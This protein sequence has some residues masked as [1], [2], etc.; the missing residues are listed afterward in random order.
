MDFEWPI[1]HGFHE[2]PIWTGR[3]FTI[4]G[5]KVSV[6]K[7]T[8]D[9]SGWNDSLTVFHETEASHGNHYID[10]ASRR[11]ALSQLKNV[12]DKEGSVILEVGSSSGYFLR[13]LKLKASNAFI[14]GS[15]CISEPLERLAK[16]TQNVPLIQFDLTKCP[17]PDNSVDA[18]VL[19][20]VLEHIKDD[21]QA[22]KQLHRILKP[23]GIVVIEVPANQELYDFYDELLKHYRRYDSEKLVL[24]S[25]K[26]GFKLLYA[27]HLGFFIYPFFRFV[28]LKNKHKNNK[29]IA[30]KQ[31]E[32][33]NMIHIGGSLANSLLYILML[34]EL[35]LGAGIRYPFGIR[36][37][38]TMK[39]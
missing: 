7:Y 35:T 4:E 25:E 19:L 21:Q 32:T 6:L 29:T 27:S 39:K 36:C 17:L 15:D 28:K 37:L 24:M 22:L 13:D 14:I 23:G 11:N 34:M 33:K 9:S 26:I 8:E 10:K 20:N 18:V 2:R 1:P 5:Q 30:E 31:M 38:L 3:G 16:Y 12:I